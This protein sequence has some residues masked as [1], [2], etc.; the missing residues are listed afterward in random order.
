MARTLKRQKQGQR[1]GETLEREKM[2]QKS[3]IDEEYALRI[4]K[5]TTC[6]QRIK[7][8]KVRQTEMTKNVCTG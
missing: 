2:R 1:Q 3:K 4:K 5:K 7:M 6:R 8:I